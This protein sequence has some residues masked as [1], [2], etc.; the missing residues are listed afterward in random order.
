[1]TIETGFEGKFCAAEPLAATAAAAAI[2]MAST[3]SAR[4]RTAE[5][6]LS[7]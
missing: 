5:C 4:V 2:M 1:M 7:S 3:V 6:I